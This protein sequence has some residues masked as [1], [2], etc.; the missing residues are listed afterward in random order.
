MFLCEFNILLAKGAL[1]LADPLTFHV[2]EVGFEAVVMEHVV[3]V[4]AQLDYGVFGLKANDT[5]GALV[6]LASLLCL[7]SCLVLP[8]GD[9]LGFLQLLEH[10]IGLTAPRLHELVVVGF[11]WN[12]RHLSLCPQF[13]IAPPTS[14][15]EGSVLG[16]KMCLR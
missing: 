11:L 2:V 7:L 16:P 14:E 12:Q 8:P 4:A 15:M 13:A 3:P 5:E 6:L 9:L 1:G 10:L